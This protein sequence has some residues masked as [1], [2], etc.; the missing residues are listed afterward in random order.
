MHQHV[1][2]EHVPF[3]IQ[4]KPHDDYKAKVNLS[5]KQAEDGKLTAFSIE[6]LEAFE[7]MDT[8]E[9]IAFIEARRRESS[10]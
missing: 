7:G 6:E 3:Q 4:M 8:N 5:F 2:K 9:A 10:S 1:M